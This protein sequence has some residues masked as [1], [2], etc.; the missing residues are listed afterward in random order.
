MAYR[1]AG[2]LEQCCRVFSEQFGVPTG[3]LDVG[4]VSTPCVD[5][6]SRGIYQ[7]RGRCS[8]CKGVGSP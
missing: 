8:V 6:S 1:L 3:D 7:C 2:F 4:Q 5:E